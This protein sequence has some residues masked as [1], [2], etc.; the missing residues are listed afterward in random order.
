M[1]DPAFKNMGI[2]E[3][4]L[5]LIEEFLKLPGGHKIV[6]DIPQDHDNFKNGT[7]CFVVE[8]PE[9]PLVK[10]GDAIPIVKYQI[11]YQGKFS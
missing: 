3:C 1:S 10:E 8:G 2:V 6:R 5:E 11:S 4:S 9:L 7:I